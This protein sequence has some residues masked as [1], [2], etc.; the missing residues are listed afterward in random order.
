MN[1]R[2]DAHQHFRRYLDIV[3][4]TFGADRLMIGS[5]WPVCTLSGDDAP[6]MG[7]VME[8]VEQLDRADKEDILGGSCACLYGIGAS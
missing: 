3:L 4:E 2:I 5:D 1:R 7:I 8:Y 6:V